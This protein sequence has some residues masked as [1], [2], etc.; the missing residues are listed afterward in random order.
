MRRAV[1][2]VRRAKQ[3]K[4]IIVGGYSMSIGEAKKLAKQITDLAEWV[5]IWNHK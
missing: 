1:P 5:Q 4:R 3:A 2:K